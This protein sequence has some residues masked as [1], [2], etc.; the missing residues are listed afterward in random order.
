MWIEVEFHEIREYIKTQTIKV[1]NPDV[2]SN[3]YLSQEL[4][5]A[6]KLIKNNCKL[7]KTKYESLQYQVKLGS[8][9]IQLW[10]KQYKD[11]EYHRVESD[12]FGRYI[13]PNLDMIIP[14]FIPPFVCT[15]S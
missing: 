6:I 3:M 15:T 9:S 7:H 13:Q 2:P 4:F 8:E 11:T 12:V 1:K 5:Q 10:I 14:L